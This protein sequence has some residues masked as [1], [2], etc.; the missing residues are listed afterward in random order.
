M[1]DSA[2]R[3]TP[4]TFDVSRPILVDPPR[5]PPREAG[6]KLLTLVS[7]VLGVAISTGTVVGVLGK[8]FF[9][10]RD[11]YNKMILRDAEDRVSFNEALKRVDSALARQ[12][13]ALNK[14]S[15]AV[16]SLKASMASRKR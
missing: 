16:E 4:Q 12:E 2:T 8:A 15:A 13:E 6:S 7:I 14:L 10:D 3:L 9:V 1:S 5:E 11:E